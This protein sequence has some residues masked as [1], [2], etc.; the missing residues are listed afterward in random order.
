MNAKRIIRLVGKAGV[1]VMCLASP[2]LANPTLS[3][4]AEHTGF[5]EYYCVTKGT[6][7]NTGSEPLREI[8]GFFQTFED[9]V[10]TGHSKGTSFLNIEPGATLEALFEAPN[11]PCDTA[12]SFVFVINA[13]MQGNS[14]VNAADCA[15]WIDGQGRVEEVRTR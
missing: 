13:C 11:V 3:I 9:G 7:T 8:N 14:F 6:L 15:S 1:A 12:D 4:E 5:R 2:V 10:Q